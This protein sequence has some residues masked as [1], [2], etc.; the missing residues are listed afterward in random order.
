MGNCF[1][2][3]RVPSTESSDHI[4]QPFHSTQVRQLLHIYNIQNIYTIYTIYTTYPQVTLHGE[5]G[6]GAQVVT[7]LPG[8]P[9]G[10]LGQEQGP[11]LVAHRPLPDPL[12]SQ[13]GECSHQT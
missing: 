12:E 3:E 10:L 7:Q 9:G 6:H 2:S 5:P 13:L 4:L 11:G 1:S 8:A